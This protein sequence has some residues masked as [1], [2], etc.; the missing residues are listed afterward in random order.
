M[1]KQC[2]PRNSHSPKAEN[3]KRGSIFSPA[4]WLV[5]SSMYCWRLSSDAFSG[6]IQLKITARARQMALAMDSEITCVRYA[7]S[8]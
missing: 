8:D 1:C 3:F 7:V 4:I 2:T 6:R 5:I